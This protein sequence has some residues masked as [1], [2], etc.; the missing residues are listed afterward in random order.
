[1]S[2]SIGVARV[3]ITNTFVL[4]DRGAVLIDPGGPGKGKA[5]LRKLARLP[6]GTEG[7]GLAVITHGHFDHIG[8]A[9][10]VRE[11]TGAKIAIHAGD[12]RWLEHG[13]FAMPPGVTRWGRALAAVVPRAL[14][15]SMHIPPLAP[16]IVISNEGLDLGP[17]G[18]AGRVVHMPGHSPGSV[19]VL[20]DSGE[21]FVGD[22]AMNGLPFCRKPSLP[23]FADDVLLLKESWRRLLALGVTTVYPAHGKPFPAERMA[24]LV[25]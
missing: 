4:R 1:M 9:G 8:A 6:G 15:R 24:S 11:A 3:G 7:I 21:A 16:D 17:Y 22:S 20:L 25:A 18:L 2:V 19:A 10:D 14:A 12:A 13:E 5:V 23:I